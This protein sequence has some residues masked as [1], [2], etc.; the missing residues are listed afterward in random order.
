LQKVF[1]FL[2]QSIAAYAEIQKGFY[3]SICD[4]D[5][6]KYF[7]VEKDGKLVNIMSANFCTNL[8]NFF[9]EFIYLK[10]NYIDPMII[11]SNFLMNCYY[12]T[13]KYQ[14]NVNYG[15][16]LEKINNCIGSG[17]ATNDCIDLCQ[18]FKI[19]QVSDM[20]I[21]KLEVYENFIQNLEN[22]INSFDGSIQESQNLVIDYDE[23][24]EDNFFANM[25]TLDENSSA[26]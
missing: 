25:N 10:I 15:V 18:E 21:G 19:G 2:S 8:I 23:K 5:H 12:N 24:F 6:N 14:L 1:F 16:T 22:L 13:N 4:H 9:S 20:F 7:G 11:N 26:T 17:G 3:C